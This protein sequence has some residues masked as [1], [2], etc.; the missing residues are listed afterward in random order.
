MKKTILFLGCVLAVGVFAG[1]A[2]TD[3][4]TTA[5]KTAPASNPVAEEEYVEYTS[6]GSRIPKKVKKS[7]V[8]TTENEST[9][10][11]ET[12]REI[13]SHGTIPA[14]NIHN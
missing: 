12:F 11:Q 4:T 13:Q 9:Q 3:T 6:I 1:C 5:K 10:T 14:S 8:A 7:T 2:S